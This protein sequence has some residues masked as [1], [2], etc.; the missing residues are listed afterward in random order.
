MAVKS[1]TKATFAG[2][3]C[4]NWE[5]INDSGRG[6]HS[7]SLCC[8]QSPIEQCT[9][10]DIYG[11]PC[12]PNPSSPGP[13]EYVLR[14]TLP[15]LV[16]YPQP[17]SGDIYHYRVEVVLQIIHRNKRKTG[18]FCDRDR[19]FTLC[20][21]P[22]IY[23]A[24]LA[25][26]NYIPYRPARG[27]DIIGQKP[28]DALAVCRGLWSGNHSISSTSPVLTCGLVHQRSTLP[29]VNTNP[30][31]NNPH[32]RPQIPSVVNIHSYWCVFHARAGT[33]GDRRPG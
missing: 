23:I 18:F 32:I 33:M 4:G 21:R 14:Q 16:S 20:V 6:F 10:T 9:E 11:L 25:H 2:R 5:I 15:Y 27:G 24:W 22:M 28:K 7:Q 12:N 29:A 31:Y 8:L 26:G 13:L 17:P 1:G 19:Q 30:G 3:L